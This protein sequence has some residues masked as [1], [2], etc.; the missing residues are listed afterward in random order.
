MNKILKKNS[1]FTLIELLVVIVIIGIL[2]GLVT[3]A[4]TSF[5]NNSHNARMVAELAGISKKLIG[6]T[7]FPA[8]NFCMEDS[9]NAGVQT[10]LTFLEMEKLPSHPLYKYTGTDGKAHENTNE[11]FLYFSDGEHYSIRVPTVG[12]K[13]YLIQESRNPNPQGIQEKCEEGWIPFGNRCVMKYEAKGKNSS[14]TVDDGHAGLN[15]ASYEAVSVAEGRPWVGNA[16]AG[17]ANRLEWQYAKDACEAIGAHLITN[18]EWMAIARDI[19]SVD[20]NWD[21]SGAKD[22]LNRGNSNKS[23]SYV[24]ST[25]NNPYTGTAG[26]WINKRTHTLSNGQVIWDI[27]GNVWEWV[28]EIRTTSELDSYF[29]NVSGV[30]NNAWHEYKLANLFNNATKLPYSMAGFLGAYNGEDNGVG[31]IYIRYT[32]SADNSNKGDTARHAFLRGGHWNY[33][34]NAGVF[35]LDLSYS[36]SYSNGHI[37]FRCAR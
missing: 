22:I 21:K 37:G 23:Q 6:E 13:G 10:L 26:D 15:P 7:E 20:S 4:A 30:S 36:P 29:K 8:G 31:K 5:I 18:A 19:E 28:D 11:C 12:N 2:A 1:S 25:D 3:I 16:T 32:A 27:A 17:D 9:D 33:G 35:A 24:A 34:A 14:G